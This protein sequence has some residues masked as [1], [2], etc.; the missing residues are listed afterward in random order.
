MS[1]TFHGIRYPLEINGE[2]GVLRREHDYDAYIAQLLRQVIFTAPGERINQPKFGA[3]LRRM[4]FAPA[5]GTATASL[6]QT[7]LRQALDAWLGQFIRADEIGV[8]S[9]G[10]KLTVNLVYTVLARRERRYLN[11]EV[12]V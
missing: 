11:L 3:G 12:T 6:V 10:E 5:G 9:D 8:D 1:D 7:T 4:V 2:L